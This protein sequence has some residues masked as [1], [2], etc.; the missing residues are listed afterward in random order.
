MAQPVS[1]VSGRAASIHCVHLNSFS[2]VGLDIAAAGIPK[3]SQTLLGSKLLF[4]NRKAATWSRPHIGPLYYQSRLRQRA[5]L[6]SYWNRPPLTAVLWAL[7]AWSCVNGVWTIS[8]S[9]AGSAGCMVDVTDLQSRSQH[10][11]ACCV[12][13]P[14]NS[15]LLQLHHL[16]A[17]LVFRIGFDVPCFQD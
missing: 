2:V 13:M 7:S 6:F 16:P 5:I 4:A 9:C 11:T 1:A 14:C 8:S 12:C 17:L 3:Q 10:M 15:F